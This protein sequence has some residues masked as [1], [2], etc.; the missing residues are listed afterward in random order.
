[1]LEEQLGK[2]QEELYRRQKEL[3]QIQGEITIAKD[4]I[5][6]VQDREVQLHEEQK[7]NEAKRAQLEEECAKLQQEYDLL[8]AAS[9]P[10]EEAV[11]AGESQLLTYRQELAE[12]RERDNR[13][14]ENLF[15]AEQKVVTLNNKQLE[16][17]FELK[18]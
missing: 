6:S 11:A 18:N 3:S 2:L 7:Q 14:K 12:C 16:L 4:R 9:T 13:L 17:Q 5:V 8:L 10:Q 15:D 1:N